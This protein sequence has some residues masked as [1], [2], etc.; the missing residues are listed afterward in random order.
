[1]LSIA[2]YLTLFSHLEGTVYFRTKVNFSKPVDF[3]KFLSPLKFYAPRSFVSKFFA[4]SQT[5]CGELVEKKNK[6]KDTKMEFW[7]RELSC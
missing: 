5:L 4:L 2:I 3:L 7:R 1:M 6:R